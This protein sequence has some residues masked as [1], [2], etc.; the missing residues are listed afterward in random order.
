[1]AVTLR[2]L[3]SDHRASDERWK[4]VALSVQEK[5]EKG[6]IFN[7]LTYIKRLFV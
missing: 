5:V 1:M 2:R 3:L 7:K 6:T 4:N